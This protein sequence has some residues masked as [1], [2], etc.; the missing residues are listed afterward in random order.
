MA[1]AIIPG[2]DTWLGDAQRQNDENDLGN[3][4][5]IGADA[6][7]ME[8][9]RVDDPAIYSLQRRHLALHRQPALHP[10]SY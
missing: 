2:G 8:A 4:M 9:S 10:A 3:A 6:C 1:Q 7:E 5:I